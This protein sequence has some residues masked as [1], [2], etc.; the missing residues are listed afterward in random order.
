[1]D[2]SR[3]KLRIKKLLGTK[4]IRDCNTAKPLLHTEFSPTREMYSFKL[5]EKKV[6]NNTNKWL[7]GATILKFLVK[8]NSDICKAKLIYIHHN[9]V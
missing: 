1:M 5:L 6:R 2:V 4:W 3:K 7:D 8:L 9:N